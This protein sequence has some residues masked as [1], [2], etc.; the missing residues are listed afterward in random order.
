M[1]GGTLVVGRAGAAPALV[2]LG[3]CCWPG[4][5][6]LVAAGA[7]GQGGCWASP[8]GG[9]GVCRGAP[10][11]GW[12]RGRSVAV[13]SRVVRVVGQGQ[14]QGAGHQGVEVR[15]VGEG[16]RWQQ[17]E[18]DDAREAVGSMAGECRRPDQG[19]RREPQ[20]GGDDSWPGVELTE[21]RPA[22]GAGPSVRSRDLDIGGRG[23]RACVGTVGSCG[24]T[25]GRVRAR[26]CAGWRCLGPASEMRRRGV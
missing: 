18:E 16:G 14:R 9:G 1:V 21:H 7:G 2:I 26:P 6:R 5:G 22:A 11:C 25:V 8:R 24:R 19:K 23:S 17:A 3:G 12:H 15:R 4:A 20:A 13:P 10:G